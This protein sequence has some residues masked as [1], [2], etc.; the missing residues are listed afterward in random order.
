MQRDSKLNYFQKLSAFVLFISILSGAV[1]TGKAQTNLQANEKSLAANADRNE[2]YADMFRRM[3]GAEFA[4]LLTK[5]VGVTDTESIEKWMDEGNKSFFRLFN[6][7]Y[8]TEAERV[9]A[10]K[11]KKNAP[12]QTKILPQP[13]VPK[14][15]VPV[16]R[17]PVRTRGAAFDSSNNVFFQNASFN[18]SNDNSFFQLSDE[19]FNETSESDEPTI[20]KNETD[21]GMQMYGTTGSTKVVGD[22]T[23]TKGETADA[24][25]IMVEGGNIGTE[26]KS[27]QFVDAFDKKERK[28]VR[29]E[30]TISWR[31]LTASCPDADGIVGGSAVTTASHKITIK[32]P[33]TIVILTR[34]VTTRMSIK[35]FVNAAAE[36]THFDMEGAAVETISGYD[37]ADRLDMGDGKISDGT[38]QIDYE[39][40]NNKPGKEVKTETGWTNEIGGEPGEM[41]MAYSRN[42]TA[43]E[44]KRIHEIAGQNVW[45][46]Y[47]QAYFYVKAAQKNWRYGGCVQVILTTPKTKLLPAETAEVSAETVHKF[48]KSKVNAELT[49]QTATESAMP[50]KYEAVTQGTFI[51]T[52]PK[53]GDNAYIAVES[54]SRR[55]IAWEPL[56][57]VK[58]KVKKSPAKPVKTPVVKKCSGGWSGKITVVKRKVEKIVKPADGRLVREINNNEETFSIDYNVLGIQDTS[59]GLVNGYFSEALMNY[60]SVRYNE[61]NYDTGKMSCDKKIIATTE[62]RK[63]EILKSALSSKRITVYVSNFGEKGYLTFGSPEIQ[64]EQIITRTYETSC[65]SYDKVNSSVDR[66]GGLIDIV[67]PSFEIQF[68][69]GA[70]SEYLLVGS[71]TIQN[72]DGSETLVTWN[73]TRDCK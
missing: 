2:I 52:A 33:Q 44:V 17:T 4:W 45:W 72:S 5:N 1:L 63:I 12:V 37:R 48:D 14:S 67:N 13:T 54:V 43:A 53:K 73:L 22:V 64:A 55:G 24:R 57:F 20:T 19:S 26:T 27:V 65:P 39:L 49:L 8:R 66:S 36:L 28:G 32:T 56:K 31:I 23:F 46:L 42:L 50:E 51:L 11:I 47:D 62:T 35:S 71:K 10:E 68:E 58:E 70:K 18:R 38:K 15:V 41:K 7:A 30:T 61:S 59:N 29:K 3:R 60:R 69:L 21:D 16:K 6:V 25:A 34:E 9:F 40:R